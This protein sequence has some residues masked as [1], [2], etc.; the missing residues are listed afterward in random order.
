MEGIRFV[1]KWYAAE[2]VP[3]H[4]MRRY[5]FLLNLIWMK[6][7][8]TAALATRLG[9]GNEVVRRARGEGY[10]RVENGASRPPEAI[11]NTID[12]M[13]GEAPREIYA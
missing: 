10:V 3:P 8:M 1:K 4:L 7:S 2:R 5:Q 11:R 9:Y 13:I 12:A 6:G